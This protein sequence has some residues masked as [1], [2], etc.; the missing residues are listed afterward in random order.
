MARAVL[1]LALCFG[2]LGSGVTQAAS[3]PAEPA[4]AFRGVDYFHRWSQ[5]EQHEFTPAGQEISNV[6]QAGYFNDRERQF[7]ATFDRH[8]DAIL[9]AFVAG[10]E[11]PVHAAAGRRALQLGRCTIES[12]ETG[13]R[14]STP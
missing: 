1:R 2:A 13:R 11:P 12:F 3:P 6:W 7:H 9:P 8:L 5:G 4:F 14:V 10:E